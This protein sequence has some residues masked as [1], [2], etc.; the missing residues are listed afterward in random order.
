[1]HPFCT[2]SFFSDYALPGYSGGGGPSRG[3]KE[4]DG[5]NPAVCLDRQ[6][7]AEADMERQ[8][9]QRTINFVH[10]IGPRK[11]SPCHMGET[12]K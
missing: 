5:R 4:G 6:T 7:A 8:V 1:M 3:G 10:F 9:T 12:G 2:S 11:I